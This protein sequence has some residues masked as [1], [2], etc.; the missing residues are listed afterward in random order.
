MWL[1]VVVIE[2]GTET[3]FSSRLLLIDED[4]LAM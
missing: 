3:S 4:Q 1:F 2:V